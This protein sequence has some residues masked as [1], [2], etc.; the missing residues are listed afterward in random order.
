M[1]NE[2]FAFL[3]GYTIVHKI[4]LLNSSVRRNLSE[5]KAF[6]CNRMIKVHVRE[7]L[8]PSEVDWF[9]H[10]C[11]CQQGLCQPDFDGF[12]RMFM[13]AYAEKKQTFA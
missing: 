2:I 3:P 10:Y 12:S 4:S 8:G 11:D 9:A 7:L 5:V 1:L 13:Y 6:G